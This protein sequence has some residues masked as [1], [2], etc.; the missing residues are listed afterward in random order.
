MWSSSRDGVL[1]TGRF[2]SREATALSEGVHEITVTAT[3]LAGLSQQASVSIEIAREPR[4]RLGV[5]REGSRVILFWDS[6]VWDYQLEATT[7]LLPADWQVVTEPVTLI[8]DQ[9]T[10][11]VEAGQATRFFRLRR[12]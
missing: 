11:Q 6:L 8:E 5:R 7:H 10:V 2:W 9:W 12:P 1:G 3:D 4:P